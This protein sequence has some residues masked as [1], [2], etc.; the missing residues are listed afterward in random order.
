MLSKVL[1]NSVLATPALVG[2]ALIV[3]SS[4]MA[5]ET[6]SVGQSV[7]E[8]DALLSEVQISA[9]ALK[10]EA[11]AA[12]AA[13]EIA[14]AEVPASASL[15]TELPS[16]TQ[17]AE[18]PVE[19]TNQVAEAQPIEALAPAAPAVVT[20]APVQVAQAAPEANTSVSSLD[21]IMQY[22]SEGGNS[23]SQVTSITQLSDVQPTDWAYQALQS[24]VE[25]YGCI[26]GYPDG[27]YRGQR[28]MTRFEFAAGMNACLDRISELIAASTAD[29]ATKE[30]LATLQRLQ[31]EFAAELAALRGRVDALEARTSEL[32]ANQF[33]TTTKLNGETI[34]AVGVPF[35]E[36]EFR[37]DDDRDV[38]END[39]VIAG[40]RVRLNFDT[41]FTGEDLLRAR[42][43]ARDFGDF[44]SF[45]DNTSWQWSSSAGDDTVRL[46]DLLY[47]FPLGDT[48][49]III[50]ANSIG[51]SDF[52]AT[53]VSPFDSGGQGSLT[54]GL[55]TPPQYNFIPG[56]TGIGAIFG[57][58]DNF[59]IDI[60]YAAG[61]A[62][63][64]SPG[65]GLFNGDY[66]L[67]AQLSF[68]S[69]F[70]DAAFTYSNSYSRDG[71]GDDGGFNLG[72]YD[73]VSDGDDTR[74]EVANIYAGQLNFK[75][76]G[77]EVG[78][79][80]MYMPVRV[81]GRGDYDVWSYH[82]TLAFPDLGGDGNMLGFVFGVPPRIAGIGS[83]GGLFG[84]LGGVPG[85][86]R[87]DASFLAEAFYRFR[88]ND[89]ISITPGV[90]FL[91]D[92][93]N[94]NG[95]QDTFVGAIRTTFTF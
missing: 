54:N 84:Q 14:S 51:D 81:L 4:A 16:A 46:D 92:P 19:A 8:A 58:G 42:L 1:W 39:Q 30:D 65:N 79:G 10:V 43:Q 55:G 18:Q 33:S 11:P 48:A 24:L 34:F 93:G 91:N 37:D 82:G 78:G 68:L 87:Q 85:N 70:L 20:P 32:E 71:F 74:P 80:V 5:A 66:G 17:V 40:Y 83:G 59:S 73:G 21:Q 61:N 88:V 3:S 36:N 94:D 86:T 90:I 75:F 77:V 62:G 95:R 47:T 35:S 12:P 57:L 45:G 25:R 89:N 28:A 26:A 72:T 44:D 56:G 53:T 41:S 76:G 15:I 6:Q 2:A 9:D 63:D 31:E 50:G 67:I 23:Q 49:Q 64:P 38:I 60:G 27:T 22:G 13:T 52:V 69:D 29:L 7:N